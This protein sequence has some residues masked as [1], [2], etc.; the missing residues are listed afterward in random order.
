MVD[1]LKGLA[2]V[3]DTA[4]GSVPSIP[5]LPVVAASKSPATISVLKS[6]IVPLS[7]TALCHYRFED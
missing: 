5:E 4:V 1:H 3:E 7:R 2:L 6:G